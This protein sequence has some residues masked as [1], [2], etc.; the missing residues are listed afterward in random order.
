MGLAR[1]PE[2]GLQPPTSQPP[3]I[4]L[5]PRL[6]FHHLP[7]SHLFLFGVKV[8][9]LLGKLSLQKLGLPGTEEVSE[10]LSQSFP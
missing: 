1:H 8:V 2:F 4:L 6:H 9:C 3:S 7:L 5:L 10:A